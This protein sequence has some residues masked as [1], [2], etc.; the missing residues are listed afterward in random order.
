MKETR[1]RW[2]GT[3]SDSL[4]RLQVLDV[5]VKSYNSS[6]EYPW[7]AVEQTNMNLTD[8]DALWGLV[9][10]EVAQ[11]ASP[12]Y[13]FLQS[14]ELFLPGL[15]DEITVGYKVDWTGSL[16]DVQNM[17]AST[18]PEAALAGTYQIDTEAYHC[19]S[20]SM[21]MYAK[22]QIYSRGAASA[23]KILDLVWTDLSANAVM[24]TR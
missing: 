16:T 6:T 11:M 2:N 9:S 23:A 3:A 14:P 20:Q 17:P 12:Q 22:W 21:A 19:G 24:G 4:D 15:V 18:F 8:V 7:W 5:S 13:S 1:F 10:P